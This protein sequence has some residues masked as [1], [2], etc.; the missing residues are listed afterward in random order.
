VEGNKGNTDKGINFI[1]KRTQMTFDFVNI[2][3][4]GKLLFSQ[5][6]LGVGSFISQ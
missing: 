2:C 5:E 4:S 1:F 6:K 3:A